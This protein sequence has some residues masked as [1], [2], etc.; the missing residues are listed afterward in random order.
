MMS[1]GEEKAV[2]ERVAAPFS[3]PPKVEKG[4]KLAG[5]SSNVAG[6]WLVEMEFLATSAR[7][8]FFLEQTRNDLQGT[9]RGE[10]LS[11]DLHGVVEGNEVRFRSSQHYEGN[12]LNYQFEGKIEGDRMEGKVAEMSTITVG[13]YGQARWTAHRH[14]HGN[15][16][17]PGAWA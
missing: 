17:T 9:H 14:D 3:H 13:E 5:P 11:G 6:Q 4:S 8:T 12:N 7:H 1:A 16:K 15:P 2:G 10:V